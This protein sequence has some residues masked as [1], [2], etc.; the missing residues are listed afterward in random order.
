M[1]DRMF[2]ESLWVV[3]TLMAVLMQSVRTAGQKYLTSDLSAI[4]ATMVRFLFGLPFAAI[5]L[6]AVLKITGATIPVL[7]LRFLT[8]TLITGLL[9]II[10]T[11]LLVHLFSLR[12]FAVGTAFVRTEAFLTAIVGSLIFGE[13]ISSIGWLS[14]IISVIGVLALTIGGNQAQGR[15]GLAILADRPAAIGLLS[16]LAFAFCSLCLREASLSLDADWMTSA[17]VTLVTMI[18]MQI[19]ILGVWMLFHHRDQ[20]TGMRRRWP[21]CVFVGATSALGSAGWFT[22]MTLERASYV[23]ALGQIE[24]LFAL[25]I[26]GSFFREK[27]SKVELIGMMCVGFGVVLLVLYG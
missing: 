4:G 10:A 23:K 15:T 9:Q 6:I 8:F 14:I 17:F 3:L 12:N 5:M 19:V 22:A 25:I 11:A 21:V 27:T 26:S 18:T 16:G 20:F 24:F 7:H 13:F 2:D 1:F